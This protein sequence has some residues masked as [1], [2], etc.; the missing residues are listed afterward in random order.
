MH[1]HIQIFRSAPDV[2]H[3]L[4]KARGIDYLAVCPAETELAIYAR[5]DPS[6]LWA[7][8]AKGKVPEWLEPVGGRGEGIKVWRVR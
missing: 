2:A 4:L 8:M 5:K 3:Q 6:G 7:Q 1:D